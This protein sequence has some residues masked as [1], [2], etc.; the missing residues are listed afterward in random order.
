MTMLKIEMEIRREALGDLIYKLVDKA[1]KFK[2][3]ELQEEA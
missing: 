2:L 3:E 1:E